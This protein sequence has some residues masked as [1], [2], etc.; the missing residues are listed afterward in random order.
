MTEH[1]QV[2]GLQVA[3]VLFDFVN[4]EA[5]PGTGLTADKFWA[6]ADKVIHDLAPKNKALLA[7]RDDIQARIDGW[8]QAR[9]GQ[10]HDALAYKAFLQDIGYL[11]PEAADFQVT[12]QNVDDE[13]ARM[14][15]PQLVVP[16][17]NA[18][19]ALNASNAR[20]G[21]LYD[22][23]Y[24]TDAI[25]EAD[26]A[27]KGKGY[28][29]VRGDKVIAFARAFLDEAAP[30]AAGS[31]VDSTGYKIV[32]GK[33]VVALKGGSNSGLRNDA[34]LIGFHGDA[35]A[36]TA[37]LLKNNGLH[38]EIQI[39]ASTPV[40]QTDAAGVKDILMEAALTTI[41][42]CEDSVAAVDADDK[43]VIYRNWLGL[44]K[45]DLSEEV[46]KGGQ[47]FTRTMNAD[48]TYT[49]VDGKELSLHGRSLLF[50]RNVGHLMTIDA[51]LDKDGNEVPEG[52][53]DGLVTSLAA[54]HS[55]NGNS[56]R[57][58]SRTGSVYIV[59]PK[60]HGP[61]EAAFTN[62]LFGRIEEVLGLPRNTL[63]VGIMDEERRT[64]VNLKACIKAAS[65]RVV[66]IN[67]GFLDRTGDE[68]HTSMEAGPMVRKADMKAEKWIGAYEN[69]N[70]DIGLSTGLQG[71]AQIGKGMWAMPDL[72]AAMLEQKI[73]HPLAGANTAWVPS[74]TAAALHALHYHK[75]DVFARQA[76]LAKRARASV[77]DILTIPLAVNPNWTPEQIKNEL[78]NNAQGILGYVVRWIDQGVGCSKVP[79]INDVGL[80]E[81]RATLRISSQ[82]IA[83][84]LRHGIVTEAQV[85]ESLKRMAPVVDRQNANDALYRPLAPNFDSNIAFQA[86][87]ELV[88]EGTK[89]P[90]GYT[91]PVLHRRRR[92]FKAANGL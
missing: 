43:V 38:F 54:I 75:V 23:L 20:W 79:D 77:D 47:T 19:F 66:F 13:I 89:Q 24:G 49:G 26:G 50:V 34:Q 59:K 81:D 27:E 76:E 32:D 9:A 15:G 62:E 16:V 28:N 90:N 14:A 17:M 57:K 37:I 61:E 31:H 48:R 85:M 46:S 60:M 52:I 1:V 22:A 39:D 83:N 65:E 72:M 35:S 41:M 84:W 7:K 42:D 80:M 91:E 44:M 30:L 18:R 69:W 68:I 88:V 70:V 53:L 92:E 10:A 86:A 33:L 21:S 2:G 63:K 78:D 4:N 55:L 40:G 73:A 71:R 64:T 11:L 74:P 3:K 58:N 56:S 45:G 51:I 67:T 12:T 82:H 36:P 29:K 25:S 6:G 8:H 87:V 5:I